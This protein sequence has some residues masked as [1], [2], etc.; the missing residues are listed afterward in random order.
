MWI[1]RN[2]NLTNSSLYT[3]TGPQVMIANISALSVEEDKAIRCCEVLNNGIMVTGDE[4]MVES[5]GM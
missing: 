1:D 2:S 5:L 4:Y 3:I